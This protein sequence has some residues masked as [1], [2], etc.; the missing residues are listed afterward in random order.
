MFGKYFKNGKVFAGWV[1]DTLDTKYRLNSYDKYNYHFVIKNGILVAKAK[2]IDEE[3]LEENPPP[4]LKN[5]KKA[6]L[7][8]NTTKCRNKHLL[9]LISITTCVIVFYTLKKRRK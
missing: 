3:W 6:T 8:Q 9:I 2:S 5:S 4:R 1:N 7:K